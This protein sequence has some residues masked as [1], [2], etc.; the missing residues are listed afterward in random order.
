M[1]SDGIL[2][3]LPSKQLVDKEVALLESM[4][5]APQDLD[6]LI[7]SFGIDAMDEIP[8]DIAVL[9]VKRG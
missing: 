1:F 7:S 9:M 4:Q 5:K 8:D 3:I 6:S 2:E